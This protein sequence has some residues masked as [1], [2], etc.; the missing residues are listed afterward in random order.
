MK[1]SQSEIEQDS[2]LLLLK[3]L[4][5]TSLPN[6]LENVERQALQEGWSHRRFLQEL[7]EIETVARHHR[8]LE[9]LLKNSKIPEGKTL[10]SLDR[11]L[12]PA[13][14][15]PQLAGL[16]EGHF[17]ERHE[18]V[19][20]FGLPGR[21]KTHFLCAVGVELIIKHG[22]P[23][24]FM[25]TYKL[26]QQL[27]EAKRDLKL[28]KMFGK[29]DRFQ[30]IILDDLGYVQQSR[31][32]MEVLFTFLSERYE[33]RSLMISSNLVFSQWEKI[34]QDPLTTM[35]AIDRLVHHSLILEFSGDSHRT[36]KIVS[37]AT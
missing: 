6:Q 33:R 8:K 32:E 7:C 34:F 37:K 3:N 5:L 13:K 22:I 29:L 19:L 25:P 9:R 10:A 27:L 36:P 1:N 2:L 18:N 35:A 21:G 31:E 11:A 20:A 23:V 26:V 15:R 4:C 30:V 28:E 17:V 12:L 24:L 14:L 16:L